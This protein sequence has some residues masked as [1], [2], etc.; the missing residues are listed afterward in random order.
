MHWVTA[1]ELYNS[2]ANAEEINLCGLRNYLTVNSAPE[3]VKNCKDLLRVVENMHKWVLTQFLNDMLI[4]SQIDHK[5][6]SL[7]S[8]QRWLSP[9]FWK[10]KK[11]AFQK[12]WKEKERWDFAITGAD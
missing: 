4:S 9:Q 1:A 6:F 11:A 7:P 5:Q 12:N 3:H 8:R 2:G 10:S